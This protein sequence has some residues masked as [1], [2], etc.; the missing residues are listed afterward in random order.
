MFVEDIVK[1]IDTDTKKK[2]FLYLLDEYEDM[3]IW[4]TMTMMKKEDTGEYISEEKLFN[5]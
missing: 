2:L 4:E 1:N 3:F 5:T